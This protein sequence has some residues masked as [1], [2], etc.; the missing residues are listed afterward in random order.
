MR[1]CGRPEPSR[2]LPEQRTSGS[3]G[4]A[5]RVDVGLKS[6]YILALM[7]DSRDRPDTRDRLLDVTAT[8]FAEAG[9][10]GTTTRRIAQEADVNEV[11]IFR[12]F[13]SKD[14]LIREALR[15]TNRQRRAL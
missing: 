4:N 7:A 9:Y 14:A 10:H 12:H 1:S 11:T 5:G 6:K 8:I 13:G 15:A 3:Q 2:S